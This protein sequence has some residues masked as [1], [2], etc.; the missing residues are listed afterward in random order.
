VGPAVG[1][2][3]RHEPAGHVVRVA[4]ARAE[5]A[6]GEAPDEDVLRPDPDRPRAH[7]LHLGKSVLPPRGVRLISDEIEDLRTRPRD[8]D[9]RLDHD[10]VTL[11]A[12]AV[13]AD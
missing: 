11:P 3:E 7:A 2:L 9:R 10:H 8:V 1:E 12:S 13:V 5:P 4:V 6:P